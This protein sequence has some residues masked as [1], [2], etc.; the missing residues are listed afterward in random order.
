MFTVFMHQNGINF[1]MICGTLGLIVALALIRSVITSFMAELQNGVIAAIQEGA[2]A[3]LND[4]SRP[5]PHCC[6]DLVALL[7]R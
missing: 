2:K 3:Y 1:A 6:G 7:L 5:L 4:R